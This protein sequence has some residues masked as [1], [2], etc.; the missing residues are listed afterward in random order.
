MSVRGYKLFFY[1][2]FKSFLFSTGV[3][4]PLQ[5]FSF[6]SKKFSFFTIVFFSPQEFS[7]LFKSF[8][9]PSGVKFF[10][11]LSK[12]IS[13]GSFKVDPIAESSF[14]AR[15]TFVR[16]DVRKK[17]GLRTANFSQRHARI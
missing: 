1:F 4:F 3:F 8:V 17:R 10:L 5:E 11:L 16:T 9:F 12:C 13:V 6:L 15:R 14:V 2:L 7:F